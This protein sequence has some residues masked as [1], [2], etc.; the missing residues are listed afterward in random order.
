MVE[1]QAAP[2]RQQLGYYAAQWLDTLDQLVARH[3]LVAFYWQTSHVGSPVNEWADI[4][5]TKALSSRPRHAVPLLPMRCCSL[6]PTLASGN[7]HAW[8][9]ECL[10]EAYQRM[11][12]ARRE[13]RRFG[14][15]VFEPGND[16]VVGSL[17]TADSM[18]LGAVRARR[19]QLADSPHVWR[20]SVAQ[21]ITQRKCT[22]GCACVGT[23]SHYQFFCQAS[24]VRVPRFQWL[25]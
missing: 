15:Q 16:L 8:N 6:R 14:T 10:L 12:F 2:H 9:M 20:S 7:W 11:L 22:F 19:M 23:W 25:E 21:R 5:A 3:E 24:E 4:E 17:G 1:V 18:D 13:E